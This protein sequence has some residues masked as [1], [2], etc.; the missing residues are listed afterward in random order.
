[1]NSRRLML[2]MA[3]FPL[4]VRWVS[5]ACCQPGTDVP[6]GRNYIH[7]SMTRR[8]RRHPLRLRPLLL[9][10]SQ[11]AGARVLLE[12]FRIADAAA[13]IR[14]TGAL[15]AVASSPEIRRAR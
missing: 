11:Q 10:A 1:M 5:L 8:T 12:D 3:R 4:V 15:A 6:L 7:R 13:A 2:N 9:S 14:R